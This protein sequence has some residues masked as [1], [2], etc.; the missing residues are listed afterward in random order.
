[1]NLETSAC[2]KPGGGWGHESALIFSGSGGPL[3]D[4]RNP[5]CCKRLPVNTENG[6][7]VRW[8]QHLWNS[9]ISPWKNQVCSE[10]NRNKE[11]AQDTLSLCQVLC[12]SYSLVL[13]PFSSCS[14]AFSHQPASSLAFHFI[15]AHL[16]WILPRAPNGTAQRT[17]YMRWAGRVAAGE[18]S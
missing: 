2:P 8:A 10:A 12:S 5:L 4:S 1:M 9:R 11:I 6:V 16:P 3:A 17:N 14:L 18:I 15:F 13:F 7:M